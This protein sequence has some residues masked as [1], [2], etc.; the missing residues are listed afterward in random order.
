MKRTTKYILDKLI[1]ISIVFICLS[2][3]LP[4]LFKSLSL[5]LIILILIIS[6]IS[7]THKPKANLNKAFILPIAFYLLHIIGALYSCDKTE[8]IFDL[9]VKLPILVLPIIFLFIPKKFLEKDYL[10]KY[11]FT[12]L[13][14]LI[15]SIFYCFSSSI[16]RSII[17]STPLISEISYTKLAASR[18]PS[19]L[20]LFASIGLILNYI[21]PIKDIIKISDIAGK[22]IKLLI[23]SLITFFLVMLNSRSGLIGMSIAYIWIIYD[24]FYNKKE[25]IQSLIAFAIIGLVYISI[26][27]L[28]ILNTRYTNAVEGI[29]ETHTKDHGENSMS[30]RRFIYV[31]SLE[32]ILEKPIYGQGIGDVKLSLENLYKEKNVEFY[33]YLNAHN[34]FLQTTM[35]LGIMGLLLLVLLFFIPIINIIR[36]REY[37]LLTIY[38]IMG[39]A[40]LFESMLERSMGAYFFIIIYLLTNIYSKN[41]YRKLGYLNI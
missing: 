37:Y 29:K 41:H 35:G 2:I 4:P 36:S 22:L 20:S 11:S 19:Y 10:S 1:L 8:A 38:L 28:N 13:I 14:G 31:N 24:M 15:I 25:R 32:L 6:F 17:N 5:T 12:I 27:N 23:F 18:H 9:Q 21:I 16:I 3:Y 39:F 40:F 34:Q 7:Q 26:F 30:Q 33:S